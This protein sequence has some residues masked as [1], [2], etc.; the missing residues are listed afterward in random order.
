MV[1][2]EDRKRKRMNNSAKNFSF[3]RKIALNL[4]KKDKSK[5]SIVT[6]RLKTG[7]DNQFLLQLLK[8]E[9]VNS[10]RIHSFLLT[11]QTFIIFAFLKRIPS[12]FKK[13]Y[14]VSK[15]NSEFL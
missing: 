5:N 15:F 4:L 13:V 6:K 7:W 8:I 10:G 12:H 11:K 3:I 14:K 9:C 1:F 2:D